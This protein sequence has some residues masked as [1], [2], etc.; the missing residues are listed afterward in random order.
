MRRK[1]NRVLLFVLSLA[2]VTNLVGF[3][4]APGQWTASG[5]LVDASVVGGDERPDTAGR[6]FWL[7]FMRN[8]QGLSPPVY[9]LFITSP[10]DTTGLV[11][12]PGLDWSEP[13]EVEAGTVTTVVLPGDAAVQNSDTV[14]DLGVHVTAED[15]VTV[16]GLNQSLYTTD[17]YLG[18]PTDILGT[19]YIIM[20]YNNISLAGSQLAIAGTSDDT[21]VTI[22]PSVTTGLRDAGVPYE[23]TL[24]QG[25]VYQLV[26]T[27]GGDIDL[28][29][30]AISADAPVAVF[31]GH[32]CVNVPPGYAYCDH[33]VEQLPPT[34][35]WGRSFVTM[36]L[37][38]RT[39]G[40]TFRFLAST[41]GTVVQVN[42]EEVATLDRGA[43]YETIVEEPSQ[44]VASEPILVAQYSNGTIWDNVTSDPFMMLIPP[45]EQFLAGYTVTTPATIFQINYINLVVPDAAVGAVMVDGEAVPADQFVPIAGSGFSGAQ[46][47]VSQGAHSLLGP[48]PFG[49]FMYGYA[50]FDSYGYPGGAS[51]AEVATVTNL[52]L[53]PQEF[54]L[55]VKT[56]HCVVATVLDQNQNPVP[57]VRVDFTASGVHARTGFTIA[58]ATGEAQFC[59]TGTVVGQ[60]T[61]TASVGGISATATVTWE[62]PTAITLGALN[63]AGGQAKGTMMAA[64][65]LV[66]SA[67]A[68]TLRRR[69]RQMHRS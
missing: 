29:G 19:D 14:E 54:S 58:S 22:T 32:E 12:M 2:V 9:S 41:D 64:A 27:N 42:G 38:T 37:A 60:D 24:D 6:D 45:F 20:A 4:H 47:A 65:A 66:L 68:V 30:T 62:E 52:L 11:E 40:D 28:T 21:T 69:Q 67:A 50:D 17:A 5:P 39:R 48:L 3:S 61:I 34:T 59:Y 1:F 26:N 33:L 36:P 46:V 10:V 15:E 7:L 56:E 16:Y 51:L 35:T 25:Q 44:I 31:G 23:I 63:A 55:P 18:L 43:F 13:F 8:P 49:A 53:T 57:G